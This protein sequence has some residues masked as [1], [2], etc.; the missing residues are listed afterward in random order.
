VARPRP[1]PTSLSELRLADL[2]T[3][4]NVH[5]TESITAA[6]RELGVTPSQVSKAIGRLE[7]VVGASLFTR[8]A[9]GLALSSAG[10]Q[11]L[12]RFQRVV[13]TLQAIDRPEKPSEGEMT[14][15]APSSLLPPIL[16]CVV[17][18]LPRMRVRGVEFPPALLRRYAAD[19]LFEVALV[20]G[21]TKGFPPKWSSIRVGELRKSLFA[22]PSLAKKLGPRPTVAQVRAASFVGPLAYDGGKLF[23]SPDDCPLA[24]EERAFAVEVGTM[25]LGLQLASECGHLIFGPVLAAQRAVERGALVELRVRGWDVSEGLFLACDAERVLARVQ[26]VIAKVVGA[27]LEGG[28]R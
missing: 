10:Q 28:R 2:A 22:S 27:A 23:S 5:R 3:F 11:M 24:P 12:P 6:A 4:L 26:G 19:G 15:A 21:S 18:A 16:P 13:E 8:G 20:A 14:L 7:R 25:D 17:S 9:R 1:R